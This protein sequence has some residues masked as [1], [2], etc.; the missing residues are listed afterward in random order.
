MKTL[1]TIISSIAVFCWVVSRPY[2]EQP[3]VIASYY[4][5]ESKGVTANGER[6][7]GST[8]TA[9]MYEYQGKLIP[10]DSLVKVTLGPSTNSVVVRINDRGPRKGLKPHRTIDLS[11]RAYRM[12]APIESGLCKVKLEILRYGK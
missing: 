2:A 9:A 8:L 4:G 12:I 1:I 7:D 3:T 6:F 10:F 11:E 5:M